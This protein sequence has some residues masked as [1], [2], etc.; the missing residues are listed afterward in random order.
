MPGKPVRAGGTARATGP[1]EGSFSDP[2]A[3]DDVRT[4]TRRV[5]GPS[6][7]SPEH[8]QARQRERHASRGHAPVA[9]RQLR[10]VSPPGRP[11]GG[12]FP[13]TRK[14][15][16]RMPSR[17]KRRRAA[18]WSAAASSHCPRPAHR[19]AARAP[20]RIPANAWRLHNAAGAGTSPPGMMRAPASCAGA[21]PP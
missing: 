15:K 1:V 18:D 19:H 7:P 4:P 20:T 8:H 12:A 3:E 2:L 21:S 9:A 6:G 13:P 14:A 5:R 10:A 16:R 11:Q 17:V